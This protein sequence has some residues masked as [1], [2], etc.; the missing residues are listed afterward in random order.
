LFWGGVGAPIWNTNQPIAVLAQVTGSAV[1]G[2]SRA[3]GS[4]GI[5][6]SA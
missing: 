4:G 6:I 5:W 3:F 2:A 1:D